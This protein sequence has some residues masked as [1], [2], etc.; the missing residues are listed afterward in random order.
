MTVFLNGRFVPAEQAVVSVFDRSFLY[1]DGL[2]ETLRLMR[3]VPLRWAA[4][5]HRFAAGAELL[6]IKLPFTSE[7]LRARA[8]ELSEQNELPEA[9]LRITLSRGVGQRGYSPKGAD[10]PTLVM[11]L[12][13]APMLEAVAPRWKLHLASLRVPAGDAFSASKSA[14]KL[15]HVLARAEADAAG[16]DEALLLNSRGEVV[17]ASSANLF[18]VEADQLHTPPTGTGALPGVTRADVMAGCLSQ[19]KTVQETLAD[20]ARL[21]R[22]AGCF[23]TSSSWG[24]VEVVGL[25][26]QP[27]ATTPLTQ[28]IREALLA[29]WRAEGDGGW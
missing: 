6:G 27:I 17:G 10:A 19:R 15:L 12:H 7:F 8:A 13:P 24:V 2:F 3:G 25:A 26:G 20:S 5:W 23:L 18:W 1:G 4:H 29:C 21:S 28:D 14:N 16:A 9:I 22:A 11:S